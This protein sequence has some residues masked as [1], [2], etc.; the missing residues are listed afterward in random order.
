MLPA[1][2]ALV[3]VHREAPRDVRV[4]LHCFD[5]F[6]PHDERK[7]VSLEMHGHRAV[8]RPRDA[9]LRLMR[10]GEHALL[11]RNRAAPDLDGKVFRRQGAREERRD[12]G[13]GRRDRARLQR[14]RT[15]CAAESCSTARIAFLGTDAS[16]PAAWYML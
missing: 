7:V 9:H 5:A 2:L 13:S 11:A 15:S 4:E 1:L 12:A 10:H 8:G 14:A 16:Y 6:R 3:R